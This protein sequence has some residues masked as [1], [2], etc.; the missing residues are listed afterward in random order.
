MM[1]KE[2]KQRIVD[3]VLNSAPRGPTGAC[4]LQFLLVERERNLD[5]D[6]KFVI[7]NRGGDCRACQ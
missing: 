3:A 4:P 6:L 1:R 5:S 2:E 7:R